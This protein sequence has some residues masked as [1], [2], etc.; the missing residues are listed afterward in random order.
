MKKLLILLLS[1]VFFTTNLFSQENIIITD[2]ESHS[3]DPSS[4]LDIYSQSKGILIPRLTD[5][6]ISS[7]ADPATGLMVFNS[8]TLSFNFFNGSSWVSFSDSQQVWNQNI[9]DVYL[10]DI[11]KNVGIGTSSPDSKLVVQADSDDA[12]TDIL[13]EVKDKNG[14][15]VFEITSS[16]IRAY[17]KDP[18]KG[19]AGGFAVGKY[20]AA[21]GDGDLFIITSDSTRVYTD[22]NGK[23][24]SGGFAVGKYGAAKS[25]SYKYFFTDSDSTRIYTDVPEDKGVSGGFAVGKY[26]AAKGNADT[27][28]FMTKDNY[29]IGHSAGKDIGSGLYNLYFGYESGLTDTAGT[30][31]IFLGHQTGYN[32]KIGKYNIFMGNKAGYHN[33][34]SVGDEKDGSRNIFMGYSSGYTNKWGYNNIYIGDSAGYL[35][36]YAHDNIFIGN[37]AGYNTEADD[38]LYGSQ[39]VFIGNSA[40]YQNIEGFYNVYIGFETGYSNLNGYG[41]TFVGGSAGI[42]NNSRDNTFIGGA[43][44]Y[45]NTG[46]QKNTALGAYSGQNNVSGSGNVF[47]GHQAGADETGSNK[48]YIENSNENSSNALIYGEFDNDILR[49]NA[50]VGIGVYSSSYKLYSVDQTTSS[51]APAVYGVHSV[52]DNYGIGVRGDG[53]Y[54]GV[55]GY[56][57]TSTGNPRGVYGY[58][59]GG[60]NAYGVYGYATG[61]TTNWAGYFNGNVN[62]TGTLSKGGGSFKI[63]HPL[64]PENKYLYH[65]FV[66]SPDMMNIYNGNIILDSNGEA[67]VNMPEWFEALNMK[68]RYQLTAIGAPG[69]NLYIKQKIKNNT[70]II[71]GGDAGMEVSWMVTGIRHD[72]FAEKNRIPIEEFKNEKDQGKYL[73]PKAYNQEDEK[74]IDFESLNDK[75][76]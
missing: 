38:I 34:G 6:Q 9:N 29:F 64:D 13:F 60:S 18:A 43:S 15:T 17:V 46:G 44:F 65:S 7:I 39:N 73:H 31:N 22:A 62:V 25:S 27:Y 5:A 66:E 21:K 72:P 16:G 75:E 12:D 8:T 30:N 42:N 47:L 32:N 74:G 35:T 1:I 59:N 50:N 68:F 54:R 45:D 53:R 23:G 70:F 3:A 71:A 58:A 69:P 57:N 20:G 56:A 33:R 48:L 76:K 11:T 51:D 2:D 63:D 4:V 49:L 61:A 36:E 52:T 40:G 67:I 14:V 28:M 41:N 10:N 37:S 26:G 19:V 24:I 55:Y